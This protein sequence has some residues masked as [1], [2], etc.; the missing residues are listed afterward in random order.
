MRK[1]TWGLFVSYLVVVSCAIEWLERD[2]GPL[3]IEEYQERYTVAGDPWVGD[4]VANLTRVLGPPDDI[5]EAKPKWCE[6]QHG[7]HVL[8]YIYYDGS[9]T[10]RSCIDT[11]VVVEETGIVIKYYCR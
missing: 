2:F 4:H 8:S 10:G 7:V 3:S 1:L 9:A 5:L 6:F 11:F